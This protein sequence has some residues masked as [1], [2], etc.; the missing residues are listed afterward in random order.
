MTTADELRAARGDP[1]VKAP[2]AGRP[3]RITW[4]VLVYHLPAHSGLKTTIRR[5]LTA[6]GA[7]YP[8]NA[9][10]TMPASPATERAFRR[11][12]H[13]IDEAGGSA[14]LLRAEAIDGE[15]DLVAAFNAAR[16][17]E[18]AEILTGCGDFAAGI[19]IMTAAG[20]FQYSELGDKDAELKRLAM[21]NDAIRMRD[22]LSAAKADS[23]L[24]SLA[25][26]RVMLDDFARR[27]YLADA[28]SITGSLPGSQE[29]PDVKLKTTQLAERT[30][31][32]ARTVRDT[33]AAALGLSQPRGRGP[34]GNGDLG[35]SL[36]AGKPDL[37]S[38][39]VRRRGSP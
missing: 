32:P 15:P 10:A 3:D 5:R 2:E 24:S 4:L 35:G 6:I 25:R 8:S 9:V 30:G 18:Y 23:A 11:L 17:H 16:E 26:C 29:Q 22:S 33:T 34:R 27:V 28:A 13:M 38:E 19:E 14:Q 21:R 39:L 37:C 7:F 20:D 12:R 36:P 1:I 31:L